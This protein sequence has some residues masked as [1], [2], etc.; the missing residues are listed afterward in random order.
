M[1]LNHLVLV[2]QPWIGTSP[3]LGSVTIVNLIYS[4][5]RPTCFDLVMGLRLTPWTYSYHLPICYCSKPIHFSLLHPLLPSQLSW[6]RIVFPP[7][8]FP[9]PLDSISR[10]C[11]YLPCRH[12]SSAQVH[13]GS[14]F[15]GCLLPSTCLHFPHACSPHSGLDRRPSPWRSQ[16]VF[17]VF[18]CP[19]V[20]FASASPSLLLHQLLLSSRIWFLCWVSFWYGVRGQGASTP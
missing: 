5:P 16:G 1:C 18:F 15:Q 10:P 13:R 11:T 17:I 20:Y 4:L 8:Y 14:P 2:F 12:L 7:G 3:D 6:A 9:Q 19:P